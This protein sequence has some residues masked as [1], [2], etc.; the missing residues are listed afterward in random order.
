MA[1]ETEQERYDRLR[2]QGETYQDFVAEQFYK[3]GIPLVNYSSRKYQFDVGENRSGFEIKND[4]IF[5]TSGNFFVEIAEKKYS[6]NRN[7][8]KSGIFRS[9][10]S[11]LYL[12]GDYEEI[13]ILGIRYLRQ[14]C[15]TNR[16]KE[17]PSNSGTSWGMLL[18]VKEVRE[19]HALKIIQCIK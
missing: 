1:I 9:D 7:F 6:T 17:V 12:I 18:P 16:Y 2:D 10:N 5:R 13:F 14:L 4:T 15:A 11:W 19:R 8:V 3:A